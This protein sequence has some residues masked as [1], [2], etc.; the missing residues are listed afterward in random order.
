MGALGVMLGLLEELQIKA[1][2]KKKESKAEET[3]PVQQDLIRHQQQEKL[4]E[5]LGPS[6]S[7]A[8]SF[9]SDHHAASEN[10]SWQNGSRSGAPSISPP[11]LLPHA[12]KHQARS[13]GESMEH[14]TLATSESSATF[15]CVANSATFD[16]VAASDFS[17]D[18]ERDPRSLPPAQVN[19]TLKQSP[20]SSFRPF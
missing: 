12:L 8:P 6:R 20:I 13:G 3:F 10:R 2:K 11:A 18:L 7:R 5:I 15:Y 19:L 16:H 4:R 14:S 17:T 9:S 1:E